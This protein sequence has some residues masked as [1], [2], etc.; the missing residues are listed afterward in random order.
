MIAWVLS[1]KTDYDAWYY[2]DPPTA[3][4][5]NHDNYHS[6]GILD[7]IFDY[8]EVTGDQDCKSIYLRGLEFYASELFET[9]GAPK[10]RNHKSYPYDI[11]GSAQ[12]ILSFS[13]ASSFDPSYAELAKKIAK[14]ADENLS[15]GTGGFL[16]SKVPQLYYEV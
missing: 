3:Y 9:D 5:K 4:V 13:K 8:L 15:S 16:L 6:G 11:H 10:W 2:T 7:G 1:K 14:W 12:G